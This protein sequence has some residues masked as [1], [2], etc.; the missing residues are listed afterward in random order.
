MESESDIWAWEIYPAQK[1]SWHPGH[2]TKTNMDQVSIF[3]CRVSF[4]GGKNN[5]H[6]MYGKFFFGFAANNNAVRSVWVDVLY[7]PWS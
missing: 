3:R 4:W 6:D 5:A 7:N 1:V 2:H